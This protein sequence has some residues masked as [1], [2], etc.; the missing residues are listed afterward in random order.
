MRIRNDQAAA[1]IQVCEKHLDD[2]GELGYACAR[3]MRML[4]FSV[5]DYLTRRDDAVR[6][7]GRPAGG[8]GA[9]YTLCPSDAGWTA[10]SEEMRELSAI[11]HD[12]D[13]TKVRADGLVGSLS[14]KEMLELSFML[15]WEETD[16]DV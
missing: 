15:D 10:F 7:H 5:A 12:V 1:A 14:G 16:G 4:T 9:G 13:I 8:G 6:R 2:R 3:N 11:E